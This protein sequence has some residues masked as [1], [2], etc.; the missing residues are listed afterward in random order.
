MLM[1]PFYV[2]KMVD[3]HHKKTLSY[4]INIYFKIFK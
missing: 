1:A 2:H 4:I 3:I